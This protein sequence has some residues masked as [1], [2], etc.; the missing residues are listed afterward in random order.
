VVSVIAGVTSPAQVLANVAA[1][2]WRL[3]AADLQ[4]LTDELAQLRA[5]T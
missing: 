3:D 4:G 1:G 2:T 5:A